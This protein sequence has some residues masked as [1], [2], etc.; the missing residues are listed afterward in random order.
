MGYF[1]NQNVPKGGTTW[2]WVLSISKFR[3]QGYKQLDQKKSMKKMGSFV[4]FPYSLPELWSLNCLKKCIFC[5]FVLTS[6]RNLSLWKQYTY[7]IETENGII[8]CVMTYYFVDISVCI[9]RILLNFCWVSIVFW[10]FNR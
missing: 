2:K 7:N 9:W 5:N 10:F 1:T 3:N 6:A 8:Y 4:L